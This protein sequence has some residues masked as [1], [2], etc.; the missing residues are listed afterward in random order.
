[1]P[2]SLRSCFLL[3]PRHARRPEPDCAEKLTA[4]RY[5]RIAAGVTP[6]SR[7]AMKI[8]VREESLSVVRAALGDVRAGCLRLGAADAPVFRAVC[9]VSRALRRPRAARR[10][11]AFPPSRASRGLPARSGAGRA[12]RGWRPQV[13]GTGL[14]GKTLGVIGYGA[15]GRLVAQRAAAF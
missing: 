11:V 2:A 9:G 3:D 7:K 10:R 6:P 5:R 14:A 4:Q 8:R 12:F 1:M 15:I 13:C